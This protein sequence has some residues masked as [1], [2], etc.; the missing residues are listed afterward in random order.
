[1]VALQA[2]GAA[3]HDFETNTLNGVRDEHWVENRGIALSHPL[4]LDSGPSA[5]S[6]LPCARFLRWTHNVA[7]NEAG[8]F[9]SLFQRK[10]VILSVPELI[11]L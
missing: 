3:H 8:Q 1:M 11:K 7:N 5:S 4:G 6:H 9:D 2:A 10:R